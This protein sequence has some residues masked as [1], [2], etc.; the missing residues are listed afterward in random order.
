MFSF[1]YKDIDIAHKLDRASSPKDEYGKHMHIFFE[2]VYFVSG[3]VNYHVEANEKILK[4]DDI[5]LIGPG[6][7]H[8]AEVNRND[9]YERYVLKFPAEFLPPHIHIQSLAENPFFIVDPY[10]GR[11]IRALDA[12]VDDF[13]E[14][15][16]YVLIKSHIQM[17]LVFL[18][19]LRKDGINQT[20]DKITRDL[21]EYI[22]RHIK[23]PLTLESIASDLHFS[24]SYLVSRF[25]KEMKTS[26]MKYVRSKKIVL[27]HSLI[28]SGGKPHEVAE[29]L[30][31][32]DYSTF[33]R[34]YT[35]LLGQSPTGVRKE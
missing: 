25:K 2:L 35:K 15:D 26:I 17:L 5:V 22:D 11:L 34:C 21:I 13:S 14:D 16:A 12:Y 24:S 1:V 3:S 19:H 6:V 29:A 28:A 10:L 33:Y 30:S 31:F 9:L 23:E 20:G 27:A 32:E 7:Y 4:S 18:S 8:F